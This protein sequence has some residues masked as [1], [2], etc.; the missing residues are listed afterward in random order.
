MKKAYAI[1]ISLMV[2]SYPCLA[3]DGNPTPQRVKE[4]VS[5]WHRTGA[6][7]TWEC[8]V[9]IRSGSL[10][11]RD[12]PAGRV[13]GSLRA[14]AKFYPNDA[15]YGPRRGIWYE[16]GPNRWVSADGVYCDEMSTN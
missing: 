5:F 1:C 9:T 4:Q 14:G 3:K 12:M 2:I 16:E 11:V 8:T 6:Y 13:V 10:R 7:A 15:T